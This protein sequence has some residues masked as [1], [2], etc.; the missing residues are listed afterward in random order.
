MKHFLMY[1]LLFVATS[2]F[3]QSPTPCGSIVERVALPS[4]YS[5]NTPLKPDPCDALA[6][7]GTEKVLTVS[8]QPEYLEIK[9]KI[10][11]V[12]EIDPDNCEAH[13]LSR[14]TVEVSREKIYVA[15]TR[16]VGGFWTVRME[17][18]MYA[19]ASRPAGC[20]ATKLPEG[21]L[22]QKYKDGS[23]IELKE[24]WVVHNGQYPTKAE[25]AA[26]TKRLKAKYPEFCRAY[27][28]LLPEGCKNQYEYKTTNSHY[29]S[30]RT[31]PS[32]KSSTTSNRTPNVH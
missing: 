15:S 9:K 23:T 29:E 20:N 14:D 24:Y 25:A 4:E 11:V 19:P 3:S 27:P 7:Y 8:T 26:A 32:R 6:D 2:L 1:T 5:T 31:S 10:R 17:L 12:V 13:E 18:L 21:A 28:Y 16:P 22:S 30:S